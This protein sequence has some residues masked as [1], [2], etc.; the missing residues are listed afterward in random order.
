[1]VLALTALGLVLCGAGARAAEDTVTIPK[2]RLQELERKEKELERLKGDLHQTKDE[3]RQLKEQKDEAVRTSSVKPLSK[4]IVTH[5]SPPL[6]S[7][8]Q[9]K[10]ADVVESMDLANYYQTD[11]AAADRKFR[12]QQFTIRGEIVGF[13]KHMFRASYR[14]VLQTPERDTRVICEFD[15]PANSTAVFTADHG[16]RLMAS[17]S[18][19]ESVLA[20]LGEKVLVKGRCKGLKDGVVWVSG[21]EFSA[22]AQ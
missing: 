18:G 13:E 2:A 21:T 5:Q 11:P 20:R 14:L 17:Y 1:M 7:V 8:P 9:L 4:P 6:A 12:G 19:A 3:N 16:A 22:L 15:P 10:P